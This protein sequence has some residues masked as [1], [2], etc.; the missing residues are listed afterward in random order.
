MSDFHAERQVSLRTKRRLAVRIL[1]FYDLLDTNV[2]KQAAL[3][4][5]DPRRAPYDRTIATITANI[6]Q[7]RAD[8]PDNA[9]SLDLAIEWVRLE[10]EEHYTDCNGGTL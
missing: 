7:L 2:L 9:A 5:D 4:L 1:M 6:E 8:Y 10:Q 3:P